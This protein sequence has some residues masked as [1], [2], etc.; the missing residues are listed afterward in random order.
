MQVFYAENFRQL[1]GLYS[2]GKRSLNLPVIKKPI[3]SKEQLWIISKAISEGK[4]IV[5]TVG[6][7]DIFHLGHATLLAQIRCRA[8]EKLKVAYQDIYLIIGV[9]DQGRAAND[10]SAIF[11]DEATRIVNVQNSGFCDMAVSR[12]GYSTDIFVDLLNR[13]ITKVST[14]S[15][16]KSIDLWFTGTDQS[17]A[18]IQRAGLIIDSINSI[19]EPS[20]YPLKAPFFFKMDRRSTHGL[21]STLLRDLVQKSNS[22][23]KLSEKIQLARRQVEKTPVLTDDAKHALLELYFSNMINDQCLAKF[24]LS[25]TDLGLPQAKL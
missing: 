8:A 23:M 17:A 2:S 18:S 5:L 10:K 13:E 24:N 4:K 9:Q 12:G 15:H 16:P 11:E 7:F 6:V 25:I 19:A 1:T 14:K 21:S 22:E 3:L 20:S